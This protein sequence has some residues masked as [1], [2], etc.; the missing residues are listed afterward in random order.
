MLKKWTRAAL[1]AAMM[2][3]VLGGCK[4]GS[5][6]PDIPEQTYTIIFDSDGGS[7]V[8]SLTK[9]SGEAPGKPAD[10]TRQ[11][12]EFLGW[13]YADD[14]QGSGE[15][16]EWDEPFYGSP[17]YPYTLKAKWLPVF[18]VTAS[19][20]AEKIKAMKETGKI[21]ASG[22]FT[23]D[24]FTKNGG[25]RDALLALLDSENLKNKL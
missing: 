18:N 5:D 22:A 17:N 10:T 7:E 13:F 21:I 3:L 25:I 15:F 11:G 2:A 1:F 19:D 16:T 4:N 12:Y 23:G 9:K 8:P 24:D 14:S 6:D 20:I